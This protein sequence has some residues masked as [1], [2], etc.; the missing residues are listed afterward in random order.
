MEVLPFG[1]VKKKLIL[2]TGALQGDTTLPVQRHTRLLQEMRHGTMYNLLLAKVQPAKA[3]AVQRAAGIAHVLGIQTTGYGAL[4]GD[5]MSDPVGT[6]D[7]H[8]GA[9]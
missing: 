7:S 9:S 8:L 3:A 5:G 1:E 2:L 6:S 4:D